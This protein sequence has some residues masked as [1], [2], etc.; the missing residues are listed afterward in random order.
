M[1]RTMA[2]MGIVL[3][4]I[5]IGLFFL[6]PWVVDYVGAGGDPNAGFGLQVL[7]ALREQFKWEYFVYLLL[8]IGVFILAVQILFDAFIWEQ[9]HLLMALAAVIL[10]ISP[11]YFLLNFLAIPDVDPSLGLESKWDF[12]RSTYWISLGLAVL[13]TIFGLIYAFFDWREYVTRRQRQ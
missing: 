12:M 10:I 9:N 13:M 6:T 8:P 11:I 4:L 3:A 2:L 1:Q 7:T 5:I